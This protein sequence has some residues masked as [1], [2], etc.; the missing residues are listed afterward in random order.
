MKLGQDWHIHTF[1]SNCASQENTVA[2]IVR[3]LDASGCALAGLCDHLDTPEQSERFVA[4]AAANRADLATLHPRCRVLVGTEATMLSPSRC[5]LD[6]TLARTLDYV[7]V[8]CNHYHLDVVENPAAGTPERYAAH[9]LDMLL[10]AATLGFATIVSH[11]FYH[12]KLGST[13]ALA[14]L[15]R[16]DEGKLSHVLCEAG[17][18]GMAFEINPSHAAVAQ[19]WFR[20]LVQE[21][22]IQGVKFTLGSDAHRLSEVAYGGKSGA[23]SAVGVCR[24]IG[25]RPTDLK[26]PAH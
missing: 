8:A 26:W 25:L 19:E 3:Q 20:A 11:P 16:Y 23:V 4:V 17:N 22:R 5:A 21:A 12:G 24:A 1:R 9:Y 2:G 15:G 14:T 6:A 18:A 10:G 13:Q 7:I